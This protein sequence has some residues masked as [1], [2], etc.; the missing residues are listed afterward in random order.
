MSRDFQPGTLIITLKQFRKPYVRF[1]QRYWIA[2]F[3][4]RISQSQ[5]QRRRSQHSQRRR[6]QGVIVISVMS[7]ILKA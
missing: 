3:D 1:S 4:N 7:D 6:R 5:R 2:E